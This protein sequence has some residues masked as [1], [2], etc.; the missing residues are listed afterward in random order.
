MVVADGVE[1]L[2]NQIPGKFVVSPDKT[3]AI[4]VETK[5]RNI[6]QITNNN[7]AEF[8]FAV[9]YDGEWSMAKIKFMKNTDGELGFYVNNNWKITSTEVTNRVIHSL[10]VKG[11]PLLSLAISLR[12]FSRIASS[13]SVDLTVTTLKSNSKEC[14]E[15]TQCIQKKE[16]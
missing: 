4:V 9:Q 11:K 2:N 7:D 3:N 14:S 1:S 8:A 5:D 13:F 16:R 12:Y 15:R 10:V 6:L